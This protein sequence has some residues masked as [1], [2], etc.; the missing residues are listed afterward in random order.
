MRAAGGKSIFNRNPIGSDDDMYL[1]AIKVTPLG[2]AIAPVSSVFE[3]PITR[4]AHVMT[5]GYREAI[6][7]I[8]VAYVQRFN[9]LSGVEEEFAEQFAYPVHSAIKPAFAQ[10]IWHQSGGTDETQGTFYIASKIHGG[11]QDH[12]SDLRIVHF[13]MPGLFI[14]H[15]FQYIVKKCVYCN[16]FYNHGQSSFLLGLNTAKLVD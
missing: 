8:C 15:R 10:H 7:G 2:G 9:C 11:Y 14:T 13:A 1:E 6:N 16:G 4:N 5:D 3:Y 12:C